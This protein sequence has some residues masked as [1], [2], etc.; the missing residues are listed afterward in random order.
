MKKLVFN[1]RF[2]E[3]KLQAL[4]KNKYLAFLSLLITIAGCAANTLIQEP[5][6]PVVGEPVIVLN[7]QCE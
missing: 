7:L 3:K 5:S 6:P 4:L 2:R 1:A